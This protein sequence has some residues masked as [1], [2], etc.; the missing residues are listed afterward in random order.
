ME[1]EAVKRYKVYQIERG[2]LVEPTHSLS[3]TRKYSDYE[4]MEEAMAAIAENNGCE[5]V[6]LPCVYTR[7]KWND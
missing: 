6:V 1:M 3:D 5:V 4:T 2:L 7:P